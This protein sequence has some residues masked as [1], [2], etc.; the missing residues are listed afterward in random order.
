MQLEMYSVTM[1]QNDSWKSLSVNRVKSESESNPSP[2]QMSESLFSGLCSSMTKYP[3]PNPN[4]TPNPTPNVPKPYSTVNFIQFRRLS[5][6]QFKSES[7]SNVQ[8]SV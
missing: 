3:N 1:T 2:S 5:V 7:E 4:P 6:N 8:L